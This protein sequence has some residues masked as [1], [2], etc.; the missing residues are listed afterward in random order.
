MSDAE[1]V[2]EAVREAFGRSRYPGD[3]F[4]QGTFEGCEPYEEVNAFKGRTDWS[5]LDPEF[6]DG[7]YSALSFFSEAGFRFFLP[8]YL[9]ADLKGKLLTADPVFHLTNGF[10]DR[11][12][13]ERKYGN[14]FVHRW[15]KSVLINP[16][17][18]GGATWE[19]Y[20]RYRLSVF[21]REEAGAIVTYL[22]WRREADS[23]AG[24]ETGLIDGAL[25]R[26]W[27]ERARTAPTSEALEQRLAEERRYLDSLGIGP[28]STPES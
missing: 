21:T 9:T 17:R 6:L 12:L 7:H 5:D 2:I 3:A 4:L 19:D 18:Y 16:R 11:S 28:H 20:A 8:A 15:G 22:R 26:F 14:V 24:L 25:D 23:E 27:L 13:E 1:V 10:T